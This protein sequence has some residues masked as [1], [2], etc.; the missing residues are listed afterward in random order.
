MTIECIV[1]LS[2]IVFL[3]K[4]VLLREEILHSQRSSRWKGVQRGLV[5][6]QKLNYKNLLVSSLERLDPL[7]WHFRVGERLA[8]VLVPSRRD[9]RG[10]NYRVL[11]RIGIDLLG[12]IAMDCQVREW[13][14]VAIVVLRRMVMT[15]F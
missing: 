1:F 14:S 2:S 13:I 5:A 4:V 12:K 10:G 8:S 9:V 3:I 15:K 7:G 6:N 11:E